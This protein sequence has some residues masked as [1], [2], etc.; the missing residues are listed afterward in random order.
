MAVCGILFVILV[1]EARTVRANGSPWYQDYITELTMPENFSDQEVKEIGADAARGGT[2][3]GGW[4][5]SWYLDWQKTTGYY[6]ESMARVGRL[7]KRNVPYYDGGE[8]GEFSMFLTPEGQIAYNAWDFH[9]W[10]M[11]KAVATTWFGLDAFFKDEK[12]FPFPNYQAHDLKQFTW[13]DGRVATNV[14][15]VVGR[16]NVDGRL[17]WNEPGMDERVTDEQA[18]K[19]GLA[20]VSKK[21][22]WGENVLGRNGWITVRQMTL[23]YANPQLRDYQAWDIARM[24]RELRPDGWHID[25]LGDNNLYRPFEFSFGAWSEETFKQFMK[26]QFTPAKLAEIGIADIDTFDIKSYLRD[27]RDT[28]KPNIYDS[29]ND[30]KWKDDLIF[31]C[32]E[33]NHARES[34]TF[35]Q[36]K[37]AAVKQAARDVGIDCMVSGNLIPVFAGFSLSADSTDVCH[38]EWNA[39]R[40]PEPS[41]RAMGFPP[42]A[43]SGY[44]ARLGSAVGRSGYSIVSLYVPHNMQGEKFDQLFLA[45]AFELLPH[46]CMLDYGHKYLDQYSPGTPRTAGI[47]S[48]FIADNREKLSRRGFVSDIGVVYDQWADI[49]S[50]TACQ[51]DVKDFFNEYAG[52]CDY[53]QDAHCQWNVLLSEKLNFEAVKNLPM[54]ILPSAMSLSDDNFKVIEEYLR[55][56]GRVLATG[57]T[58]E[59]F[60]PEGFLMKRPTD[61]LKPLEKYAGFQRVAGQPAASYWLSRQNAPRLHELLSGLV[62]VLKTDAESSVGVT[63]SRSLHGEP[64]SLSLDVNNNNYDVKSNR[65]TPTRPF[66]VKFKIP[67]DFSPPFAVTVAEPEKQTRELAGDSIRFDPDSR[68]LTLKIEPFECYQFLQIKPEKEN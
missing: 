38:F 14:Y 35:H 59:R 13:P 12:L 65:F 7:F 21:D 31:K 18:E 51:L 64:L 23:D 11:K 41:R 6:K 58:G 28:S 47:Y 8:V 53:M 57:K 10:D 24:T 42:K 26:R 43:R 62:P 22:F 45:Q 54:M 9:R 30:S 27:R 3:F 61:P 34:A 1:F 16:R 46:R 68:E 66:E 2:V 20:A 32:Y 67:A 37:Y 15:D 44:V 17:A 52:W 40:D 63:L 50:S 19:S 4:Y 55:N 5:G 25:N 36:A 48:R 60:G 39:G 29:Y 56:G 33:I 49:A